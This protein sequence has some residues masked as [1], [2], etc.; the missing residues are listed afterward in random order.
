MFC[1][2][3]KQEKVKQGLGE[4]RKSSASFR[5]GEVKL[6]RALVS[7]QIDPIMDNTQACQFVHRYTLSPCLLT[8][9][10]A[11]TIKLYEHTIQC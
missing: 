3:H 9:P 7:L 5:L 8:P 10:R 2:K 11:N 4:N 1:G 6:G